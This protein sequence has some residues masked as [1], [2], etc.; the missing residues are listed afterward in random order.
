[1]SGIAQCLQS[2]LT[3]VD[4]IIE[5]KDQ[6]LV[7]CFVTTGCDVEVPIGILKYGPKKLF[8]YVRIYIIG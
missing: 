7:V 2:P 8:F 5:T 3:A 1:M 6:T 4:K